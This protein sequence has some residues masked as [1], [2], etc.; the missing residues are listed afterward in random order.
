M[1]F[2]KRRRQTCSTERH[3]TGNPTGMLIL[4]GRNEEIYQSAL[5]DRRRLQLAADVCLP[6]RA[7]DRQTGPPG[8]RCGKAFKLGMRC[9]HGICVRRDS[10]SK[11]TFWATDIFDD[12]NIPHKETYP[13]MLVLP[14]IAINTPIHV[15]ARHSPRARLESTRKNRSAP[16]PNYFKGAWGVFGINLVV[17]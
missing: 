5:A 6:S 7:L 14:K 11:P 3:V 4:P 17:C 8:L 15:R 1:I 16:L 9:A 10:I 12:F 13:A 2:W